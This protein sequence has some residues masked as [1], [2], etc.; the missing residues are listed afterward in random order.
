MDPLPPI[1][2]AREKRISLLVVTWQARPLPNRQIFW[3]PAQ[4]LSTTF[5][6]HPVGMATCHTNRLFY[7]TLPPLPVSKGLARI[8][9]FRTGLARTD[10]IIVTPPPDLITVRMSP[11]PKICGF[12]AGNYTR[13]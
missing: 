9:D 2:Q 13:T 3:N 1:S 7:G 10:W 6:R 12:K 5:D 4:I 8:V 11:A